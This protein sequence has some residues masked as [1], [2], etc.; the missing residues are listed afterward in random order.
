MPI[1]EDD[2]RIIYT[3]RNLEDINAAVKEGLRILLLSCNPS[4]PFE[5]KVSV[6]KHVTQG[7]YRLDLDP[8]L[9]HWNPQE[10]WQWRHALALN[11]Y[12]PLFK[13]AFAAYLIPADLSVGERVWLDD[14]IEDLLGTISGQGLGCHRLESAYARWNGR[15]FAI[16]YDKKRVGLT[17]G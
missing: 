5:Y 15:S 7:T 11:Y 2:A 4:P 6:Y 8:R 13:N 16:E 17:V 3:A 10:F 14:L 12:P 1:F 9:H